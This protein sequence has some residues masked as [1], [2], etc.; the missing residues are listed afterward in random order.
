MI[1]MREIAKRTG[2]SVSTVSLVMNH[3]DEGRVNPQTAAMVRETAHKLGYKVNPLARSLRTNSTRIL[4]FISDEVATTPF[5]GGMI[6]GAQTAAS[7][8]GYM[9]I[10]VSTDGGVREDDEIDALK[11][12]GVDGF[13]YAEMSNRVTDV[14]S[15]L[16]DYPTVLADATDRNGTIPSVVPDEFSIGYDA[17]SYLVKAGCQRIAYVGCDE[18]GVKQAQSGRLAGYQAA[19]R[20]GGMQYDES[21][22]TN[23]TEPKT[24]LESVHELFDRERPDGFFCFNDARTLYVYE[25]AAQHGLAIGKDI[26]VVGVDHHRVFAETLYPALT[27]VELP[28]FEMG[29][30]AAVKLVSLID[31]QAVT[32]LKPPTTT[33]AIPPID[34]NTPKIHCTLLEKGSVALH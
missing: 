20:D 3:H 17:T 28:H 34:A 24:A 16:L 9:L 25:T 7:Q 14:P 23:V 5:A 4:G 12:Y 8:L 6:L 29:Y 26:S 31:A 30:W 27:T 10:T 15:K 32:G 11:R 22:V 19:L 18:P 2:V 13:L 33:A 21:L 1:T